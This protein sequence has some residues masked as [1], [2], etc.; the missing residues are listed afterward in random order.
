MNHEISRRAL[1]AGAGLAVAAE[2][3]HINQAEAFDKEQFTPESAAATF[4]QDEWSKNSENWEINEYGG[5][6]LLPNPTGD[7]S[8]V[9]LTATTAGEFYID[10]QSPDPLGSDGAQ[11]GV[12]AITMVVDGS[13]PEAQT[14]DVRGGTIWPQD[15]SDFNAFRDN[16]YNQVITKE[17]VE[18]PG[19]IVLPIG[20]APG[21]AC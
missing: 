19:I 8:R 17:A 5:A 7:V 3:L 1:L 6:H 10:V 4:G 16:L 20:F 14:V 11:W 21:E 12:R 18:Q 9:K 13:T 15:Q 2:A